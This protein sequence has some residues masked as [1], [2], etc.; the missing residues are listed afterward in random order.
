MMSLTCPFIRM[1][2]HLYVCHSCWQDGGGRA[3]TRRRARC[4]GEMR[5][6]MPLPA[7]PQSVDHTPNGAASPPYAG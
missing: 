1:P 7:R 6:T 3:S 5:P 2:A 4:K